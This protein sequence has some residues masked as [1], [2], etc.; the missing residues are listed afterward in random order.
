MAI[1]L[2]IQPGTEPGDRMIMVKYS[3][4]RSMCLLLADTS[5][6]RAE[7]AL[8]VASASAGIRIDAPQYAPIRTREVLSNDRRKFRGGTRERG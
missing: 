6:D 3:D 2:M 4:G 7:P 5:I 8:H 1:R